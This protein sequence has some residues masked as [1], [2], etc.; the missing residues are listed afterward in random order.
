MRPR[1]TRLASAV[2]TRAGRDGQAA[3][4][5]CVR[6]GLPHQ[7]QRPQILELPEIFAQVVDLLHDVRVRART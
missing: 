7:I 4:H 5:A 1:S 2:R 3:L 6:A